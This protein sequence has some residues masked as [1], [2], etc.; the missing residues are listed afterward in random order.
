MNLKQHYVWWVIFFSIFFR[1]FL[2]VLVFSFIVFLIKSTHTFD[3]GNRHLYFATATLFFSSF[4]HQY[5][6]FFRCSCVCVCDF[7]VVVGYSYSP[8]PQWFQIR[9]CLQRIQSNGWILFLMH[10]SHDRELIDM[11]RLYGRRW[12]YSWMYVQSVWYV[13]FVLRMRVVFVCIGLTHNHTKP[14]C[15]CVYT[16]YKFSVRT[17]VHRCTSGNL[18]EKCYI[19]FRFSM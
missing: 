17:Y 4:S 10:K 18:R 6:S 7:N 15:V 13:I 8:I 1:L 5:F 12:K 2:I 3:L 9:M 11:Q 19:L 16:F 14:L